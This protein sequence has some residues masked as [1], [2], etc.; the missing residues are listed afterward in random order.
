[1][2]SSKPGGPYARREV[3]GCRPL[4]TVTLLNRLLLIVFGAG[5]IPIVPAGIFLFYFQ[6]RARSDISMLQQNVSQMGALMMDREAED[7]SRRF[8]L[9]WAPNASYVNAANL[10]SALKR[11]PEFLYLAFTGP[12]GR[13]MLSGGAPELKRY[14]GYLDLSR[15]ALFAK[16]VREGKPELGGF[17]MLYDMPICRLV[18]P[19]GG[20]YYAFA[21]VNLR[22]LLQKLRSQRLGATG[23]LLLADSEGNSIP[24]S[25]AF[26][27]FDPAEVRDI[28]RR[29]PVFG[30]EGKKGAYIGAAAGARDF[31]LFVVALEDRAEAFSG[32]NRLTW[33]MAFF[34]LAFATAFYLSALR[35]TRRLGMPVGAL[36]DG[37]VYCWDD[38]YYG[39]LGN[40]T[41]TAS[42]E[43]VKVDFSAYS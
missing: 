22:D 17:A 43:P 23:G 16:A 41:Q 24:L 1:V 3:A 26:E 37:A 2:T 10:E 21:A 19:L 6:A 42:K 11:N 39:Q 34:L 30:I 36:M 13:Y 14:L 7:L 20:G 40:G 18:Y 29:G 35:F 9:M 38:N 33:L 32:I 8:E 27:K 5:L 28:L 15:D 12:D 31:G 25:G 4:I